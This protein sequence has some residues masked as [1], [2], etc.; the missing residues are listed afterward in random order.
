MFVHITK[1][2]GTVGIQKVWLRFPQL[3]SLETGIC[4]DSLGE[5]LWEILLGKVWI[6]SV[7]KDFLSF[8]FFFMVSRVSKHDSHVVWNKI[9]QVFNSPLYVPPLSLIQSSMIKGR[10]AKSGERANS[11]TEG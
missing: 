4:G 7:R 10:L 6:T 5:M 11:N 9:L 2:P 8:F 1:F 3:S